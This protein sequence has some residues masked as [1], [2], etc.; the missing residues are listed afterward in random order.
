MNGG[1]GGF[2]LGEPIWTNPNPTANF[3][4]QTIPLD[5]SGNALFIIIIKTRKDNDIKPRFITTVY[6]DS[7]YRTYTIYGTG[8]G[9]SRTVTPSASGLAISNSS[10]GS[11][12]YCIPLYIFKVTPSDLKLDKYIL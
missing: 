1:D 6:V 7:S 12:E 4:A 8:T 2:E 11:A 5:M 3:N 9:V 10:N